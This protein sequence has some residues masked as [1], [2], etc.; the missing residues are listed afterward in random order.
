[1]LSD[2][3]RKELL[4]N[5]LVQY[6]LYFKKACRHGKDT[7]TGS[8]AGG[9]VADSTFIKLDQVRPQTD[10]MAVGINGQGLI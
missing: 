7:L 9:K 1:M 6:Y 3:I 8:K 5:R 4:S 10:T 2:C